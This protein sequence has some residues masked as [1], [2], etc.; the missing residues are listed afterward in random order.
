MM[1]SVEEKDPA[2]LGVKVKLT[3]QEEPAARDPV[4]EEAPLKSVA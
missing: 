4:Q 1:V 3:M 2:A